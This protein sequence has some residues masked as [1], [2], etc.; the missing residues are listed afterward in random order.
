MLKRPVLW[1]NRHADLIFSYGGGITTLLTKLG[2]PSTKIIDI[3]TGIDPSWCIQ[4]TA[5]PV[6]VPIR[7]CFVGRFERR[8]GIEELH[9]AL[10]K[11]G[12]THKYQFD[13]VGPIPPSKRIQQAN[14]TYHGS[15]N[16]T[17]ALIQILDASDILVAPSHSEGMP[18]VIMEAM[19]RGLAIV[20][21]RVG[22]IESVVDES[23]GW[24]VEPGNSESL[25]DILLQILSSSPEIVFRKKE[26]SSQRIRLF[27]WD[28][29]AEQTID[30]I[31]KLVG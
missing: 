4:Q 24:Y 23:N 29:I 3:P 7:F 22:A 17:E 5:R 16:D 27:S 18:N 31:R 8:K 15:I 13:F 11:M 10:K 2:I 20:T 9:N 6:G 26:A 12:E 19:A 25:K 21:T 28:K 30:K 14:I 1:N